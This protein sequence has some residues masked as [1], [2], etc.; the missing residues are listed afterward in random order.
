MSDTLPEPAVRFDTY[1]SSSIHAS[2]ILSTVTRKNTKCERLFRSALW[3][4][5]YRFR[6]NVD[7][8]PGKPDV[9]FRKE[10]VVVFCDGDFWHGWNWRER[11][12][13]LRTGA[14]PS[15]WIGKIERNI[16]RD[17]R[18][19]SELAAQGFKV[20]RFWEHEILSE[21]EKCVEKVVAVVSQRV[22]SSLQ[23]RELTVRKAVH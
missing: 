19:N 18:V 14:N 2:R 22:K 9:V 8:L 1:K 11:E 7:S 20:L 3:K 17:K 23:K 16:Q 13:K 12:A 6:K 21:I 15:Y 5:G 10:K 4:K